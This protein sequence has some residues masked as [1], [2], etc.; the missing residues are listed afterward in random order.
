M[1]RTASVVTGKKEIEEEF[2]QR[3]LNPKTRNFAKG[4]YK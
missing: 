4:I 2:T 3:R 1:N